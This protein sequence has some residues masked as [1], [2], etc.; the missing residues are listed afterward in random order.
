MFRMALVLW[1]VLGLGFT[2]VGCE[3]GRERE[4]TPSGEI[5]RERER[6]TLPNDRGLDIETPRGRSET[7][8]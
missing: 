2:V 6:E 5:E 8:R 3:R 1:F 7:E 4:T